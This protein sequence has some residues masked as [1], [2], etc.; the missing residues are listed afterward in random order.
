MRVL[1]P[2]PFVE[3]PERLVEL[4]SF[5]ACADGR[6]EADDVWREVGA[7]HGAQQIQGLLPLAGGAGNGLGGLGR[8]TGKR[9]A[10]GQSVPRAKNLVQACGMF[11]C[12]LFQALG[13]LFCLLLQ[14]LF[15]P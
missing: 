5:G 4:A 2:A 1:W 3:E 15:L 9:G 8:G 12:L 11:F 6:R 13:M 14:Q 7:G 10:P